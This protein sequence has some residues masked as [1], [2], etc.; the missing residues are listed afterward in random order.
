MSA[1]C[2]HSVRPFISYAR[3]DFAFA[4]RL[5][6]D[7]SRLG[8]EPWM[9]VEELTGGTDWQAAVR[10]A[11]RESTHFLALISRSAVIKRGYVQK[12]VRQAL[13]LLDE[14]AAGHV[15][16]VPV[17]VDDSQPRH[18]PLQRLH[19]IDMFDSYSDG[20]RQLEIALR[21]RARDQVV[22]ELWDTKASRLPVRVL[23]CQD[24]GRDFIFTMQAQQDFAQQGRNAEPQRC[25]DC[26]LPS[27]EA[28]CT[29][30]GGHA[31]VPFEPTPGKPVL[32]RACFRGR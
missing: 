15:F 32:C 16:I 10:H 21:L 20:L 1:T 6:A 26:A 2:A 28:N 22:Q 8:A 29:S 30:C 17:R 9:D 24:C 27:Y 3:E 4:K 11:I 19:W 18:E 31:E 14:F 7:L 13:D 12:E 5:Y 25:R 23:V